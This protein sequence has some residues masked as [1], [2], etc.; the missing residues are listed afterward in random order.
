MRTFLRFIP[1]AAGLAAMFLMA[2]CDKLRSRDQQ[3]QGVHDFGSAKYSDAVEHFTKAVQLDPTN[4]TA[5]SYL[6]TAYYAQWIPGAESPQNKEFADHA[7]EEFKKV[8][9]LNPKDT[10]ALSYLGNMAYQEALPLPDDQKIAK[11]N[12]AADWFHKQLEADPNNKQAYYYLGVIAY[13]K[14]HPQLMLAELNLHMKS[15]E[16]GPLKDKK[17]KDQLR[18]DYGP[19]V[20][21]GIA[22]LKKAIDIDHDYADAMVYEQLLIRE[23]AYLD[24]DRQDYDKEVAM[25]DQIRDQSM[26]AKRR[27]DAKAAQAASTGGIVQDEAK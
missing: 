5:V 18:Q 9:D 13:G 1:A 11:F 25:A 17:V 19:I 6:A 26:D 21:Q 24:D 14:W 2:G 23:K 10:T 20:D 8:L 15:D 7:R 12:E 27:N 4:S 3:N 16:P 22:D